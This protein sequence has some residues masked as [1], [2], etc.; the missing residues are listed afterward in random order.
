MDKQKYNQVIDI[1]KK[2]IAN[3]KWDYH[4]F[5]VG[6]CCRDYLSD[7][8]IKDIDLVV[9]L[10]NGGIEF[11][12]WLQNK[13]LTKGS[14]VTYPHYGT[15][16]FHLKEVPDVELE[17][18]QTRMES[19]RNMET[20]NPD[21]AYG[22]IDDDCTR[23]DFTYNAIYQNV[24][25]KE[26]CDYNGNSLKD[27]GN[28]IL[29]TCGDPK[30]IFTEDPLRILRAIRFTCRFA[31]AIED[32]TFA[33]MKVYANRL[34]IISK[35]RIQDE[36]SKMMTSGNPELAIKL[37]FETGAYKYIFGEMQTKYI[38]QR[39]IDA[40]ENLKTNNSIEHNNLEV[41]LATVYSFIPDFEDIMKKLKFSN[42]IIEKVRFYLKIFNDIN[43]TILTPRDVRK[44]QYNAKSYDNLFNACAIFLA[45][46]CEKEK[47]E[48]ILSMTKKMIENGMAMFGYKLPINGDD[49]ME[50]LNIG[51]SKK[52]KD[53][54]NSFMDMAYI[55]PFITKEQCENVLKCNYCYDEA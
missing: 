11:A 32:R 23:R 38:P 44:L 42:D 52:I 21:T 5:S 39:M 45:V 8:E 49:I 20:R 19:Y 37:L 48:K 4:V 36:F 53:Y 34:E 50:I 28:N 3:A 40:L 22:T 25:T 33:G 15:A 6:G 54:L 24:T 41:Y 14:V 16:M 9:D 51:P 46:K 43:F 26:F 13:G 2:I 29:R 47:I 18:V 7:R 35:E 17:A 27:L 1:L 55:N 10:P 30:I 31:S 12:E